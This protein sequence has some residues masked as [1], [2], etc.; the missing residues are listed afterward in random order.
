M[1]WRQRCARTLRGDSRG[2]ESYVVRHRLSGQWVTGGY[3]ERDPATPRI[4]CFRGN[5]FA[6]KDRI[7]AFGPTAAPIHPEGLF[8]VFDSLPSIDRAG[9]SGRRNR[10]KPAVYHP[11]MVLGAHQ[12]AQTCSH[13]HTRGRRSAQVVIS[14][15]GVDVQD[16]ATRG[17]TL[18]GRCAVGGDAAQTLRGLQRFGTRPQP[19]QTFQASLR[20][21]CAHFRGPRH[22]YIGEQA[23]SANAGMPPRSAER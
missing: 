5:G 7:S 16:A 11:G 18:G 2:C 19:Q 8:A 22:G 12:T 14:G 3:T 9:P 20:R 4:W 17:A 21:A 6:S 23:A 15:T 10:A 13:L 1:M